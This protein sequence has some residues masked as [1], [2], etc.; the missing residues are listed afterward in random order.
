MANIVLNPLFNRDVDVPLAALIRVEAPAEVSAALARENV[1]PARGQCSVVTLCRVTEDGDV[2]D[3]R[4]SVVS[5]H[6]RT[7]INARACQVFPNAPEGWTLTLNR[8][9]DQFQFAP[10]A[11]QSHWVQASRL[12]LQWYTQYVPNAPPRN[13]VACTQQ[14]I[15]ENGL[16]DFQ[17]RL[18][19]RPA[20]DPKI[21]EAMLVALPVTTAAISNLLS[22]D[23]AREGLGYPVLLLSEEPVMTVGPRLQAGA[24]NFG[25]PCSPILCMTRTAVLP[26]SVDVLVTTLSL[27]GT[28]TTPRLV[29]AEEFEQ[30]TALDPVQTALVPAEWRW[31][32]QPP[33]DDLNDN[34]GEFKSLSSCLFMSAVG[35]PGGL[36][37]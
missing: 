14:E 36:P 30:A 33:E 2:A 1:S 26:S 7:K 23:L 18:C 22:P 17:V 20:E 10:L 24:D 29:A 8:D 25:L 13:Q 12:G 11:S 32:Y 31:P 28:A 37:G 34:T 15:T 21:A 4:L 6:H 5:N 16:T 9:Y 27:W 3:A 19:I 35:C